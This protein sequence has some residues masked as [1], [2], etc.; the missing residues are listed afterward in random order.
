[1]IKKCISFALIASLFIAGF[2][3]PDAIAR[4]SDWRIK[5]DPVYVVFCPEAEFSYIGTLEDRVYALTGYENMSVD[6]EMKTPTQW[7]TIT[8]LPDGV[9]RL[10]PDIGE[11]EIQ[12]RLFTLSH[13]SVPVSF[14]YKETEIRAPGGSVRMIQDEETGKF[15]RVS[16][17]NAQKA[18]QAWDQI[19]K[20]SAEGFDSVTGINAYALL[21]EFARLS[22]FSEITDLTDGN[23]YG[24]SISTTKADIKEFPYSLSLT[25][26]Q[27]AGTILYRLIQVEGK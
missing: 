16:V 8:S 4:L 1:M 7:E 24:G 13:K 27:N 18:I 14:R 3:L 25:F 26:S 11:G 19:Q 15:L 22:G 20:Y 10:F 12:S 23:S 9:N 21:K 2:F 6:Y 17:I 5:T